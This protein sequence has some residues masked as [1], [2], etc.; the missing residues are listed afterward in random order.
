M[1]FYST[2]QPALPVALIAGL[3]GCAAVVAVMAA[4]RGR[5]LRPSWLQAP[6]LV[7]RLGTIALL[8]FILLNPSVNVSTPTKTSHSAVLLD[9]SASMTLAGTESG[10]RWEEALKWTHDLGASLK[11]AG[12]PEPEMHRFAGD[13]T[14]ISAA[15]LQA[16]SNLPNGQQTKLAGALE[17]L[18]SSG[19]GTSIDHVI[20]VSDG[21]TQ[22]AS[23]L[24]AALGG[25]HDA[26]IR[27]STKVVGRDV[28]ARNATLLSVLPPRMVRAQSRVI[29]PVELEAGGVT[30]NE[31]FELI[32][33]D[34]EGAEV[35]RQPV[36]FSSPS[37]DSGF[38]TASRKVSFVTPAQT[39]RYTLE[40]SGPGTE[41][42]LEDNRFSFTLEVVTTKLRVLL[43]EGTHAKRSLGSEG[44][45][46]N[47][48]EMITAACTGTGE[49]ECV[50]FT[51][52]SQYVDKPNLFAV[53]FAN[54]EML[55]DSSRPFPTT[56]EELHSYDV[57]MVSDVPVG[58][59]SPEQMQW[60]V[61][62][63]VERGGGFLMAGGNT[64]FDTGN[65]DRTP[66]EKITPV[67]ML[68]Y[69]DGH[70]GKAL[71]VT[72]PLSVRTH[73]IWQM[74][75]DAKE[76]AAILDTH[77]KFGGMNRV[78]RAKP[79]ATVLA[80]VQDEP[81]QPVIAAQNYGRG[82]SIAYL[83]DPNG[84]WGEY[85]I[86]WS[87]DNAPT[88]G[89][90]IEL[91]QGAS[92]TTHPSEARAPATPRPPH[93]SPYYAAFWV[94]T[95]KWLAENSIRWRRDKL[96]GKILAAQARPGTP[97]PVAAEFLAESDPAKIAVQEIGARLDVPGSPRVRLIYDRDRR[98][99]TGTLS[100]PADLTVKEVQ[101]LFDTTAGRE[102]LTD[103]VHCGVLVQN[104]E[105]TRSAPDVTLMTELAQAGG[106]T[107]LTT[108]ESAVAACRA[109]SEA[110]AAR[111]AR[112]WPAPIWSRWPWWS[113]VLALLSLEWVLRRAG[114]YTP[115]T[116]VSTSA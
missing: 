3:G 91:G 30:P 20:V 114:R 70:Y 47:D 8:T 54:G 64:A 50:T 79:G 63:V 88:L 5:P 84:G 65:Y 104:S 61:D 67:D 98:E 103:A 55:V 7:L 116:P 29:V 33:R 89:D 23:R 12:L 68:D 19:S 42:T 78:R 101:V 97:L 115:R 81:E 43:A 62:W 71:E 96:S 82:R 85:V 52:V 92:L 16:D 4:M 75:P 66:W 109:A 93:P 9:A 72:I 38:A 60:V 35:A 25:L 86:R 105:Y 76:N 34:E 17:K 99:F 24:S 51:P 26:G 110:R 102:S 36:R 87:S 108:P 77:P 69:G 106:G 41:A 10:T 95:M 39:A 1:D 13:S 58:N 80:V 14:I 56:R 57:I 27:V 48:I 6:V 74:T 44:H 107:V 22:D 112:A 94:N 73:P 40:L 90:R 11:S 83:P 15:M 28:P 31:N 37:P 46:V 113:A 49:I 2:L 18:A 21:C 100:V 111:D 59:F 53:K 32:L 45:F